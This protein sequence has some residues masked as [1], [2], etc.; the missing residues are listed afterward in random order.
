MTEEKKP[1]KAKKE[2]KEIDIEKVMSDLDALDAKKEAIEKEEEDLISDDVK[3]AVIKDLKA[4][5][6]RF[7]IKSYQLFPSRK[8]SDEAEE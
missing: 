1:A 4:K 5:I 8:K 7:N 2:V 6:K 3:K